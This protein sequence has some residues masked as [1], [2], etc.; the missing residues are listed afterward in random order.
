M[1]LILA[2]AHLF[3]GDGSTAPERTMFHRALSAIRKETLERKSSFTQEY[4][5]ALEMCAALHGPAATGTTR[6]LRA[7]ATTGLMPAP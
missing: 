1:E 2:V 5:G 6:E 4:R 7:A 3:K